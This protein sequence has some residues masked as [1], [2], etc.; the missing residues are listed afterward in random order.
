VA[1]AQRGAS[2]TA[3]GNPTTGFTNTIPAS[4]VTGDYLLQAVTSRD[5]TSGSAN[6][7]CTD[8]DTGGNT[9]TTIANT[10]DKKAWLFGK[11]ATSATAGKTITIAAAVGSCSGVGKAFSD[12]SKGATPYANIVTEPNISTD[13]A[14]ADFTPTF[15]NCMVIALIH[16][17]VND[18]AVTSLSF[19][20]LGATTATDNLSTGGSDC[21][22]CFGHALQSG[23]PVAVGGLTWAQNNN[24]TYSTTFALIPNETLVAT[25]PVV[26]V[27]APTAVAA[28]SIALTATA[29]L[30]T[31]TAPT[32]ELVEGGDD[33]TTLEAG[34]PLVTFT[35]PAA[36]VTT[37]HTLVATSPT[38]TMTAAT[39]TL[40][41][42]MTTLL[43]G[44]PTVTLSAPTAELI[45]TGGVGVALADLTTKFKTYINTV[46]DAGVGVTADNKTDTTTLFTKHIPTVKAHASVGGQVD[47]ANTMYNLYT[48]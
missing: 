3:A 47:D 20:T 18:N 37:A 6:V 29:P 14:H 38:V 11:R 12:V 23:S 5:S 41:V 19:A 39:A 1:I 4:V 44:A 7:T 35:A 28:P 2:W 24:A 25:A 26:T 15:G 8:N 10:A 9:W 16:N 31:I 32:A 40:L 21:G 43:A 33:G 45:V 22:T 27:T 17:Y 34:A 30:I 42:G 48:P 46:Y 36:T 13:E